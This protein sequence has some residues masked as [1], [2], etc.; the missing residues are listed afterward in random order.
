MI[1]CQDLYAELRINHLVTGRTLPTDKDLGHFWLGYIRMQGHL[2][3]TA[4]LVNLDRLGKQLEYSAQL[5]CTHWGQ[6]EP[7][8]VYTLFLI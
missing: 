2:Q 4:H 1:D 8:L 5:G 3:M 6:E 7:K